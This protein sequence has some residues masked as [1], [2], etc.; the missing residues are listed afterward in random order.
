VKF[1]LKLLVRL[2]LCL[3]AYLVVAFITLDF[4]IRKWH[5]VARLLYLCYATTI[6][7]MV[8]AEATE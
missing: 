2:G 3:I 8:N 5:W 7:M 4:D 6:V 1:I